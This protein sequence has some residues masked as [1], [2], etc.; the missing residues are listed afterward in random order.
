[1]KYD[2][3]LRVTGLTCKQY[4]RYRSFRSHKLFLSFYYHMSMEAK[5]P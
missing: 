2:S 3:P 5:D 4:N 1:M